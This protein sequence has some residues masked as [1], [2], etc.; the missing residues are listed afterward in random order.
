MLEEKT[1]DELVAEA[2]ITGRLTLVGSHQVDKPLDLRGLHVDASTATIVC[3]GEGLIIAG[4][5]ASSPVNPTQRFYNVQSI[6][7]LA[8]KIMGAKGQTICV[9]RSNSIEL[10]ATTE[11]KPWRN[12]S[13]AYS[14]FN[15][16]FVNKIVL[17]SKGPR[18]AW[19]SENTFNLRRCE[20]FGT[21]TDAKH[22]RCN[23]NI[24][25]GGTFE[26]HSRIVLQ[27]ATDCKFNNI[28]F[29]GHPTVEFGKD[30]ARNTIINTWDSSESDH[31]HNNAEEV[32]DRGVSNKV[33]DSELITKTRT[34]IA[35]NSILNDSYSDRLTGPSSSSVLLEAPIVSVIAGDEILG[36]TDGR[37]GY[38][39]ELYFYDSEF[40]LLQ[41]KKHWVSSAQITWELY[42]SFLGQGTG[43]SSSQAAIQRAAI[44]D[45]VAYVRCNMRGSYRQQQ[46]QTAK[47][48]TLYHVTS[49]IVPFRG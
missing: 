3:S 6:N 2:R 24:V 38:R 36:T 10:E 48:A 12:Y 15:F 25:N 35:S 8:I 9:E 41:P 11:T 7:G 27:H 19:I 46:N 28:R 1:L 47:I 33:I 26:G 31:L 37:N 42:D 18:N 13:I 16:G 29:E 32:V 30:T 17:S 5:N 34:Q 4:G 20:W 21:I 49:Q 40:E 43:T 44:D 45:G 39:F 14:V 22:H 23:H